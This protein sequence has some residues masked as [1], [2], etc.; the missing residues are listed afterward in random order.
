MPVMSCHVIVQVMQY[1]LDAHYFKA[2][3]IQKLLLFS[4]HWHYGADVINT[5]S[6]AAAARV[7]IVCTS[8]TEVHCSFM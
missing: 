6:I 7:L 8:S 4:V 5:F 1:T 3:T 2:H